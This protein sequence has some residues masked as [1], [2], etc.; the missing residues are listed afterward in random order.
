MEIPSRSTAIITKS[1]S[2]PRPFSRRNGWLH[3]S[4][5]CQHY[6]SQDQNQPPPIP[7]RPH[8]SLSPVLQF[9][10]D[11]KSFDRSAVSNAVFSMPR[12]QNHSHNFPFCG[13]LMLIASNASTLES[14]T[15]KTDSN[16]VQKSW[17]RP[18]AEIQHLLTVDV[19]R[20]A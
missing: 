7:S 6:S 10:F 12:Y 15:V 4:Q 2:S 17:A 14:A 13:T 8:I 9:D 11:Y 1:M 3:P 18:I 5:F 16:I 19:C 20:E